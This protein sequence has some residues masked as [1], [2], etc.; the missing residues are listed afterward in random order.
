[1]T[2]VRPNWIVDED[3]TVRDGFTGEVVDSP[4]QSMMHLITPDPPEPNRSQGSP[5]AP[6]QHDPD[7]GGIV[8]PYMA[9]R[10]EAMRRYPLDDE[11]PGKD[12]HSVTRQAFI[13]G[14]EWEAQRGRA[15]P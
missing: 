1:M 4:A 14:A 10:I 13:D 15:D 9:R 2:E 12:P 5:D 6:D 8:P 11:R 3:G 7:Q